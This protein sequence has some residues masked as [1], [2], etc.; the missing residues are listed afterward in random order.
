MSYK[1]KFDEL[2]KAQRFEEARAL[3]EEKR[4][5]LMRNL[6]ISP[7]WDGFLTIS[8]VIRRQ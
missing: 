5:L 3:L 8:V 4:D 7:I 6:S 1:E 2:V